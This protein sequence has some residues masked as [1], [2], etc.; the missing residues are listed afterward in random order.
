MIGEAVGQWFLRRWRRR[1]RE[2]LRDTNFD[3]VCRACGNPMQ[4]ARWKERCN[5]GG[6]CAWGGLFVC[7]ACGEAVWHQVQT[8]IPNPT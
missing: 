1:Q 4:F 8:V 5:E 7:H 2:A 6:G 3:G